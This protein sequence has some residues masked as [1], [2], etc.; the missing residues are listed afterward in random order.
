MPTDS[1]R[2]FAIARFAVALI[3]TSGAASADEIWV[4]LGPA[5]DGAHGYTTLARFAAHSGARC[6][7]IVLDGKSRA[8]DRRASIGNFS[9]LVCE[10]LVPEGTRTASIRNENLPLPKW[11]KNDKPNVVVIGDT[12]CRIKKGGEEGPA[13]ADAKWNIQKCNVPADWPFE[14]VANNAAAAHPDLVIHVGDYLY[15]EKN[16]DGVKNCPGGPAGD[17]M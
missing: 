14:Q 13:S 11:G 16:C 10:A 4:E 12:G 7:A 2:P 15:R 9:A 3:L 8:M 17:M 6:P 1:K 5:A